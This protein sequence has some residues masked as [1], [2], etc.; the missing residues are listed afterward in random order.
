MSERL[1]LFIDESGDCG[2]NDGTGSNST[3]YAE[4][5]LQITE[6]GLPRVRKHMAYWRYI[7]GIY[8][9]LSSLPQDRSLE[10][11]LRPICELHH[12]GIIRITCVFLDKLKY[13]GPY[14]KISHHRGPHPLWFRNFIH[15]QLLEFH[16]SRYL[17]NGR[18]VDLIF[19]RFEMTKDETDNLKEYLQRN[20]NLPRFERIS[21]VDSQYV[22]PIQ[23]VSQLVNRM[24]DIA[25]NCCKPQDESLIREIVAI[26]DI[27]NI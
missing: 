7:Q 15:R 14:L 3:Y 16:F 13:T 24:G 9:E 10:I 4:L 26:K 18:N 19:D 22:E 11:Y 20:V 6:S 1:F 8:G 12:M 17:A 27:T 23:F 2:D 21:D 25:R 5:A